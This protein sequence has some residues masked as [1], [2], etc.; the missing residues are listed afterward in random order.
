MRIFLLAT[1]LL[2]SQFL[3]S[4]TAS[5]AKQATPDYYTIKS[6]QQ[7]DNSWGYDVYRNGKL[8]IHQPSIPAVAG[9]KGFVKR[10]DAERTAE[11]VIEKMKAGMMPP[12]VTIEDLKKINVLN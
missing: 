5:S 3:F 7:P 1:F 11:L 2:A 6:F 10:S 8:T 9:N 4:Q 12:T